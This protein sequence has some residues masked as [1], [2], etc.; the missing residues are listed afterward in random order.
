MGSMHRERSRR[1]A[2]CR[3]I[4]VVLLIGCLCLAA[5]AAAEGQ[6][7]SIRVESTPP[8]AGVCLDSADESGNCLAFDSTGS[9]EF[10]NIAGDSSHS[11]SVYRD[12][13]QTYRSEVY[14]SPG[15]EAVV[16]AVLQPLASGTTTI[17]PAPAPTSPAAPD[18]LQG[19]IAAF[20]N[21]VS[22]TGTGTTGGRPGAGSTGAPGSGAVVTVTPASITPVPAPANGKITAA[23]FFILDNAYDASMTVKETI[24]WK[25]VNRVYIAFATVHDGVLTDY[26]S[27]STAEDSAS[28][29]VNG[30][31]IRNMV[32]LVRQGNPD[33][34]IL[35]SSN[36]GGEMDSEYLRAAED[37]QKFAGSVVAYMKEYDLDGYDMDW[38]SSGINDD[39]PQLTA[40]LSACHASFAAAG[41][42]PHGHPYI[43]THTVWPGVESPQ[44]VAGL[45]DSVDQLNLMTYGSGNNYDLVSYADSYAQAGFPYG[46]MVGGLESEAGYD[47]GGGPDTQVS[48]AAKCAYMKEHDLAGLFEWRM[49]NDMRSGDGP[50]TFQV[51]GWMSNCMAG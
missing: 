2:F 43:L 27:G 15:Q 24:P 16:R 35:I 20:W 37:P 14:V 41:N 21:L 18:L 48:V 46:K 11:V 51:T 47:D 50:P 38:E 6:D 28:R 31:K 22:G 49:D 3:I 19:I 45:K 4:A 8:G 12:G 25:K 36:F 1:T 39:A 29:D 30:G 7:G 42:N 13:Y 23:Y 5:L 40:L 33:A 9:A 32:A 34:T 26:P 44:T 10:S 17:P